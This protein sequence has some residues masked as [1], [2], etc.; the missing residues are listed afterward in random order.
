MAT[1]GLSGIGAVATASTASTS[2]AAVASGS[3]APSSAECLVVGTGSLLAACLEQQS[4]HNQR[5]DTV[6][7]LSSEA[8]AATTSYSRL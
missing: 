5:M 6:I 1:G 4:K 8:L 3:S 2:I 7:F